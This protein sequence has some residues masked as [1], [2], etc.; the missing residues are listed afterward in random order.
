MREADAEEDEDGEDE[1]EEEEDDDDED[2]DDF[3]YYYPED[4]ENDPEYN[5]EELWK[6]EYQVQCYPLDYHGYLALL[7]F[8]RRFHKHQLL[9][10]KREAFAAAFPLSPA[11]WL[12]WIEDEKRPQQQG[13]TLRPRRLAY[14]H[15]LFERAVEEYASVDVWAAYLVHV[16][17]TDQG[18]Q[19]GNEA[20]LE[21]VRSIYE[22]AITKIGL[23]TTEAARVWEAYAGF[24]VAVLE[25]MEGDASGSSTER[26]LAS[27]VDRVYDVYKRWVS[28]GIE[29]V[30]RAW[31]QFQE[32]LKGRAEG[33]KAQKPVSAWEKMH[34]A[35][36][37][38]L[39]K[40]QMYEEAISQRHGDKGQQARLDP[41]AAVEGYDAALPA[42][43][44]YIEME[45]S[46][47]S[48]T[49]IQAIYERAILYSPV[50][51][52]LWWKYCRYLEH[53]LQIDSIT[54][55]AYKRAFR[56]CP[57]DVTLATSYLRLLE[58]VDK[59]EDHEGIVLK[60]CQWSQKASDVATVH[61]QR[62]NCLRRQGAVANRAL[63]NA[64]FRDL[65]QQI[66]EHFPDL[67]GS[68][69]TE[70]DATDV[71][72]ILAVYELWSRLEAFVHGDVASAR[73]I[74]EQ[75][76]KEKPFRSHTW[77]RYIYVERNLFRGSSEVRNLFKRCYSR[78]F[79]PLHGCKD[80]CV[81]WLKFEEEEGTLKQYEDARKKCN[82]VIE[83]VDAVLMQQY[84]QQQQQQV[85][86]VSQPK[87]RKERRAARAAGTPAPSRIKDP[88][89]KQPHTV[90]SSAAEGDPS[91]SGE[92][93]K[94]GDGSGDTKDEGQKRPRR[95]ETSKDSHQPDA[96]DHMDEDGPQ[97]SEQKEPN[98]NDNTTVFVANL[99]FKVVEEDLR[100]EFGSCGDVVN[101]RLIRDKTTNKSRGFA[102]VQFDSHESR[103]A[104]LSKEGKELQGRPMF[105][106]A[107]NSNARGRA[108]RGGGSGLGG[109]G[110]G[111]GRGRGGRGGAFNFDRRREDP[112]GQDGTAQPPSAHGGV[113]ASS[114]SS[115]GLMR[116]RSMMRKGDA[117]GDD[118]GGALTNDQFRSLFVKAKDSETKG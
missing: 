46:G 15:G 63:I 32:F 75:V 4:E 49:H 6:L 99:A 21:R 91:T 96:V 3:A 79:Y 92:K 48:P 71:E 61:L 40:R 112:N 89:Q 102:Y 85:Q 31:Q 82:P 107:S 103:E 81:A 113:R 88:P 104:A 55:A 11:L 95:G 94:R 7:A 1:D 58:R 66:N 35:A 62:I 101:V 108:A 9:R 84:E 117:K 74:W 2:Y 73:D 22:R 83:R 12:E 97:G 110:R 116:P 30:E 114:T 54:L 37:E 90:P 86:T 109:R 34:Q 13:K 72:A 43:T 23:H 45:E 115:A 118:A 51:V 68:F 105:V 111:R 65:V 77:I 67:L 44:R 41:S 76:V 27:Q 14:I 80:V 36:C 47:G 25:S 93:R 69:E 24:E 106:S 17:E 60:C 64:C 33:E 10:R 52:Q 16:Q 59:T 87:N 18:V 53:S 50:N 29:G 56:N 19:D 70:P 26:Q 20:A 5:V 38:S 8:C 42:F 98:F 28:V 100:A 39:E 78:K 57:W